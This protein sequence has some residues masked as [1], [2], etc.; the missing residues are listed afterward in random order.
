MTTIGEST[1]QVSLS[2]QSHP[3]RLGLLARMAFQ[4]LDLV[5][6]NAEELTI[7]DQ[8]R[9][10]FFSDSHR[11]DRGRSDVFAGNEALFFYTLQ[12][13]YHSGFTYV[14]VGDGDELW[15]NGRFEV[16]RRAYDRIFGLLHD[17]DL[18][19][20]LYLIIGNHELQRGRWDLMSKDGIPT[21]EG[22]VLRY[23][24]TGRQI[25]VTHGHQA[26]FLSDQLMRVSRP[27]VRN[28]WKGLR[29]LGVQRLAIPQKL[30]GQGRIESALAGWLEANCQP[31]ICG[32]THRA[33][34]PLADE[35]PYFNTGTCS[36][37]GFMTGIEIQN[38]EIAMIKWS[39]DMPIKGDGAIRLR[40]EL[41]SPP[42]KLTLI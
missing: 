38:G 28:L 33:H 5:L 4:R 39:L 32:H 10:I 6:K 22:V 11:G 31:M 23:N 30:S 29:R 7:T 14:E 35:L 36:Y 26:D 17:F 37:P 24:R 15:Q 27:A 3:V 12:H 9:L 8:S 20:R 42:R 1:S 21:R 25:F 19:R 41:M 18:A 40:R 13:Y 2:K 34:F 16:V